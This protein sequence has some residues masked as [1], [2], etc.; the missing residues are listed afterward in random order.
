MSTKQMGVIIHWNEAKMFGFVAIRTPDGKRLTFFLHA[1]HIQ[2][3]D[4]IGGIPQ[5]NNTVYFDVQPHPKGPKAVHA[6]VV[7]H[8]VVLSKLAGAR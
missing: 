5:L 4:T 8:T 6:E 7:D 1:S 2:S 3:I